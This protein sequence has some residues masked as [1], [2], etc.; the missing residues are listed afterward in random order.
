MLANFFKTLSLRRPETG[1]CKE[2]QEP[3]RLLRKVTY[4]RFFRAA[5]FASRA[6]LRSA[7][8]G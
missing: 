4:L 2:R 1:H 5:Y 7:S 6:A 8:V 3:S